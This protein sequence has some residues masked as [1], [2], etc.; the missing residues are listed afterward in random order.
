[1]ILV[2]HIAIAL[3]NLIQTGFLLFAPSQKKLTSTYVLLGGTIASG[4][5][6]IVTKPAHMM[7]TCVEGLLFIGFTVG[8]IVVAKRR[9]AKETA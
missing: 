5:Y 4:T 8:G 9:L 2:L 6:L 3:T 7:Q 1:M